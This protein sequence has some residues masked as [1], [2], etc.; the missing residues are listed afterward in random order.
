MY[1]IQWPIPVLVQAFHPDHEHPT[2]HVRH[3][4]PIT[5]RNNQIATMVSVFFYEGNDFLTV[6]AASSIQ[7]KLQK[8]V[9]HPRHSCR[10]LQSN[11]IRP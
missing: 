9:V 1:P 4:K 3:T 11:N 8:T 2:V 10:L 7:G 6:N 5:Q